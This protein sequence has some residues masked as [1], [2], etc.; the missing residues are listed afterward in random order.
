MW[1]ERDKEKNEIKN[2]KVKELNFKYMYIGS[3]SI[4]NW[5]FITC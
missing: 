1:W 4:F 3:L 2:V 5:I